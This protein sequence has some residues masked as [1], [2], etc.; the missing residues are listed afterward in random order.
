MFAVLLTMDDCEG[1]TSVGHE[2]PNPTAKQ[3]VDAIGKLDGKRHSIVGLRGPDPAYLLVGG[4]NQG[5][6][7]ISVTL[8]GTQ[9][10]SV[11]NTDHPEGTSSL[12]VGGQRV[13]YE[14]RVLVS[15]DAANAVATT[16]AKSGELDSRYEWTPY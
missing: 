3:I 2:F 13:D 14:R 1:V 7:V 5:A 15:R 6:Y 12:V 4:G 9:Y 11:A 8:D 16:F 10:F